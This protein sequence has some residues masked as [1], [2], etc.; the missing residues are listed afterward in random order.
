MKKRTQEESERAALVHRAQ[1]DGL[2]RHHGKLEEHTVGLEHDAAKQ[3]DRL[4]H[5]ETQIDSLS[6]EAG[7]ERPDMGQTASMEIADHLQPS[8]V[9]VAAIHERLPDLSLGLPVPDAADAWSA[10]V[11]DVDSYVAKH[12]IDVNR[13]PLD[14][15]LPPHRAAEICSRFEKDFGTSSWDRWGLWCHN[16]GHSHRHAT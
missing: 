10:Y 14:Q 11:R 15:L 7:L 6:A 3:S 2:H 9:E 16:P 1:L 5:L 8:A 12:G 13:D 4:S